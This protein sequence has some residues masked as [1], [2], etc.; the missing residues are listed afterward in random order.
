MLF[1]SAH[2]N[3]FRESAERGDRYGVIDGDIAIINRTVWNK[4]CEEAGLSPKALLGHLKSKGLIITS[5][6]AYT[7]TKRIDGVAVHCVWMRL[8]PDDGEPGDYDD[9][10]L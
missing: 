6:K 3:Q 9:L 8:P 7:K 5:G 4:A 2:V 1:R 10:P